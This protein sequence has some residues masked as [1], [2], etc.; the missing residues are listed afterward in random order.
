VAFSPDGK[1]LASA[2]A[3]KTVRLWDVASRQPLATL[4][5]HENIVWSVA[6]SPDGKVLA[7]AS[8]DNTVR[9]WDVAPLADRRPWPERIAE[10]ER[11]Y[12]LRL[13]GIDLKPLSAP[14]HPKPGSITKLGL[15]RRKGAVDS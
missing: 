10:A 7:S 1:I 3:D 12:Q 6:F 4:S 11:R 13:V 15:L 2:S 5:G 9:L 14:D 8:A